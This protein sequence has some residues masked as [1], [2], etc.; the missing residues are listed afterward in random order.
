MLIRVAV[1]V[2]WVVTSNFNSSP[3]TRTQTHPLLEHLHRA[4]FEFEELEPDDEMS[5]EVDMSARRWGRSSRRSVA[6]R[7]M[8]SFAPWCFT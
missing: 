8:G 3:A 6:W 1:R 7:R 5:H 2:E 4:I